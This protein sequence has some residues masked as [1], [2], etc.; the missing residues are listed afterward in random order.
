M[1]VDVKPLTWGLIDIE[2]LELLRKRGMKPLALG[3]E[4]WERLVSCTRH[5]GPLAVGDSTHTVERVPGEKTSDSKT[6]VMNFS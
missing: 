2:V 1:T 5:L 6:T 3:Y 4:G